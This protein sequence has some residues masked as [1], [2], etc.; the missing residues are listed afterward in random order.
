VTGTKIES[1][2]PTV[3]YVNT[4]YDNQVSLGQTIASEIED[5]GDITWRQLLEEVREESLPSGEELDPWLEDNYR[6]TPGQLD[7]KL[8]KDEVESWYSSI[9]YWVD[10]YVGAGAQAYD[11]V[12]EIEL[13][14]IDKE[15][16]G[17][18]HGV[19]LWCT[20]AN[21]PRK[22]LVIDDETAARWL[23]QACRERGTAIVIEF[24]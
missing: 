13:F 12:S 20:T 21:G 2:T 1:P 15:G 14:P 18:A 22:F 19:H 16:E 11:L 6:I 7:V 8:S 17:S 23:V 10:F 5:F 3:L 4:A 9:A 24:V